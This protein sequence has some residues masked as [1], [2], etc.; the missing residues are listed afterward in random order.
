MTPAYNYN[1]LGLQIFRISSFYDNSHAPPPSLP[2]EQG[3][4]EKQL[5]R[6][7]E[8]TPF[9]QDKRD[10]V[11]VPPVVLK[12]CTREPW[13]KPLVQRWATVEWRARRL[14]ATRRLMPVR[15]RP[16]AR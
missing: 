4:T 13:P 8:L 10:A 16:G 14:A 7:K 3:L 6:A 11:L 9:M 15:S 2:I 5:H 12:L 1:P